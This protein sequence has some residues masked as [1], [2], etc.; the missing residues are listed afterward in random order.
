MENQEKIV[1]A[2]ASFYKQSYFFNDEFL[3]LPRAVKD[4][5]REM[6]IL[7][8]QHICGVVSLGF[9]STGEVFLEATGAEDDFGYDEIG[10]KYAIN[11]LIREEEEFFQS[12]SSWYM[13][14]A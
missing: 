12:L 8:A 5:I 13:N 3:G 1:I 10:A 11:Q 7:K 14:L 6:L 2:A 9:Y 4:E